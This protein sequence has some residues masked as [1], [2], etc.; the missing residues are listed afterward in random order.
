MSV[1]EDLS[2]SDSYTVTMKDALNVTLYGLALIILPFLPA[3]NL[4]F[5]VGF[6]IA[7]RI[8]Y[9]PS[10]GFC[11]LVANGVDLLIKKY[12]GNRKEILTGVMAVLMIFALKTFNRNFVWKDEE[13]LYRFVGISL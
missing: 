12:T 7:E 3:T 4:F 5:Y 1:S 8:L 9:I 11:L 13:S 6:I 2:D 10:I